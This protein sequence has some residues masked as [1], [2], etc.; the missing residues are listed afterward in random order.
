MD[1]EDGIFSMDSPKNEPSFSIDVEVL[2]DDITK[3]EV[4]VIVNAAH[5]HLTGGGGV[6]GAIHAAAGQKLLGECLQLYG[7]PEGEARMTNG[8]D[9]PAKYVIHTCGPVWTPNNQAHHKANHKAKQTLVNCY[10]NCLN[11]AEMQG[12]KS[13]AFPCISTGAY[14]FPKELAAE[15]AIHTIYE[16]FHRYVGQVAN[17]EG[18]Y[19]DM[20]EIVCFT[21]KDVDIY[22]QAIKNEEESRIPLKCDRNDGLI[23][24]YCG[25]PGE[26]RRPKDK[27]CIREHHED[28]KIDEPNTN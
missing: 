28:I 13:S 17:F 1:L 4:D 7:C 24:V 22:R 8:Y 16:W 2:K 27:N 9:L 21:D 14:A 5:E 19:L 6:D 26:C 25:G 23:C 3:R 10:K 18:C 15:I 11:M 12:L 20:V